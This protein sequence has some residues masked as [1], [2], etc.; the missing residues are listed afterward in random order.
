MKTS[1]SPW[2]E[3]D[4]GI[5][6]KLR[7]AATCGGQFCGS[8]LARA[9]PRDCQW[10]P[11]ASGAWR[12]TASAGA[13]TGSACT[14]RSLSVL[15]PVTAGVVAVGCVIPG[16]DLFQ[17]L[18]A[19]SRSTGGAVPLDRSDPYHSDPG[20]EFIRVEAANNGGTTSVSFNILGP[21]D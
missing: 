9:W 18:A 12:R 11:L 14:R 15:T 6:V 3:A 7:N 10:P 16:H 4:N 1:D 2:F 13:L 5:Y 21:S 17:P 19:Y 8:A 20:G